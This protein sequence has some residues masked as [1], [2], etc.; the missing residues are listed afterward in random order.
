MSLRKLSMLIAVLASLLLATPRAHANAS[1]V[2]LGVAG[3]L[4]YIPTNVR[5]GQLTQQV[6]TGYSW[7][8]FVDIPLLETF[9]ISPSTILYELDLGNGKNPATDIDLAFKFIVPVGALH[10]SV[11]GLGGLTEEELQYDWHLGALAYVGLNLVA[12]LDVFVQAQYKKIFR[13]AGNLDD[14]HGFLGAMFRFY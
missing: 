11:G 6:G 7:G 8:F 2:G 14:V 5:H 12:N 4:A 1:G 9:Y 3:G 10:L 13:D